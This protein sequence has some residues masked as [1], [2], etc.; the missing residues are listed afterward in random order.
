M[1]NRT[2]GAAVTVRLTSYCRLLGLLVVFSIRG[3]IAHL[4]LDRRLLVLV[5]SGT[6]LGEKGV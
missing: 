4:D 5:A 2:Y 3:C 6:S 1:M